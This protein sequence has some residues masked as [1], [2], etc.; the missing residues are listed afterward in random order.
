MIVQWLARKI[1][2]LDSQAANRSLARYLAYAFSEILLIVIGIL[3]AL[4]LDQWH[5]NRKQELQ[6]WDSMERVY[7][8]VLD[9][10]GLVERQLDSIVL[11]LEI[12]DTLLRD[13]EAY[14]DNRMVQMLYFLDQPRVV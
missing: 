13:P 8:A 11:Q 12:I 3:I 7:N 6:F 2:Q 9:D 14:D 4:Y 10:L 5:E 1:G